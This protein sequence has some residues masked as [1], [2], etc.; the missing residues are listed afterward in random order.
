MKIATI[1]MTAS[2]TLSS[3]TASASTWVQYDIFGE[4]TSWA[5]DYGHDPFG[6]TSSHA[7]A[8]GTFFIDLDA[9]DHGIPAPSFF[10]GHSEWFDAHAYDSSL[11]FSYN[12][13]QDDCGHAYCANWNIE[14]NFA[15]GS[16]SNFP[17]HLPVIKN[18]YFTAE[19]SSHWYLKDT[20]G[21]AFAVKTK[22]VKNPDSWRFEV[23]DV[24]EP[25]TWAM[26]LGGLGLV[27][28]ALRSRRTTTV[29][30]VKTPPH[31]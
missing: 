10:D 15:P 21:Y 22:I 7:A 11:T 12:L 25:A 4:G 19:E 1:V 5:I 30:S 24:P 16:F 3:G 31:C 26:M 29:F 8:H 23:S 18:S 28:G 6:W 14:L 2:L 20:D 9:A 17:G 13:I 27:G